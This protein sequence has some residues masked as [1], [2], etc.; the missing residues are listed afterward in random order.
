MIVSQKTN[1]SAIIIIGILFFVFG[2]VT[3]LNG[4]LITYV[5]LAFGL[6]T[7]SKAFL[8]TTAFYMAYFFLALPSSWIL[9]KTGMK[10]G[11]AIGLLIMAAGTFVFGQFAT[12]RNYPV[13]LA[14]LFIIGSGLSLLQTASN[15]YVSILGPIESAARRISIMGI[16]NKIAGI[17]SPIL[18]SLLVLKGINQLEEKVNNVP[19]AKVKEAILV[20]FASKVYLPYM[21]MAIVLVLLAAWILK[22]PLP[23]IEA[24]VVNKSSAAGESNPKTNLFQFPHLWLGAFCIFVYVGAEVMAGDAI[25]T[26]GKGFDIPTDETKYFTSFTLGAMLVGYIIGLATIPK[27]ISQQKAL[28]VSA[29]LGILFTAAAFLTKGYVSVGFVAALGL[30]NALMWPA[31]FP[32]A[33]SG[34]GKFTERGSAILIM[35]IAGGAVIP[36]IFAGLKDQ[37]HFQAVFFLIMIPCYAFIL[38]YAVKGYRVGKT[39]TPLSHVRL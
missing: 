11:M 15:P 1:R 23:E 30:A 37:Y 27:Y 5:K 36:K 31:I 12:H 24:S 10:S 17:I 6:N 21:V 7:D 38:Y 34:L 14:G 29:I 22:S 3:W 33:I 39:S 4:P 26:Y 2:F 25:G 13:S 35:G 8:V 28:A 32:L 9:E 20:E 16:C 18:L 19:D